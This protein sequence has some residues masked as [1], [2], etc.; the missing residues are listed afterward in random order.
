MLTASQ[1]HHAID[2]GAEF[3]VTP[4]VLPE[5]ADACRHRGIPF[6]L[7]AFTASE[8]WAAHELGSSLVKVFPAGTGG[9][10]HIKDLRGPF[11]HIGLVPSGGVTPANARSFLDAGAV[12]LFA[13]SDLASAALVEA[14]RYDDIRARAE[15]FRA[16]VSR[17]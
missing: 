16:A 11:P 8:V 2:A 17:S 1:A 10:S 9:P 12:A 6:L 14:E 4:A 7:G 15:S 13:G 5:V 3:V